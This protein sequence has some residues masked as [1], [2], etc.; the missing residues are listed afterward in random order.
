M[1]EHVYDAPMTEG[2]PL[3]FELPQWVA[4]APFE[5]YLGMRI[6]AAGEG[7]ASLSMPFKAKLAQGWGLMHGGAV[8]ALADTALAIAIKGLL[9]DGT[10]FAT[11]EMSLSFHAP[12][13]GGRVRAEARVTEQEERTLKGETE[14]FDEKGVKVATFRAVFKVKKR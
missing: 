2:E 12:V 3:P 13:K 8:T 10:L 4:P 9:P 14:L 6:D 5:E 11:I 1:Y 7:R